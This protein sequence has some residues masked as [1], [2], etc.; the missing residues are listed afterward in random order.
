MG[1]KNGRNHSIL[2]IGTVQSLKNNSIYT[3]KNL[4]N[5]KGILTSQH[6][7]QPTTFIGNK[8][9]HSNNI[10]SKQQINL[11]QN[12]SHQADQEPSAKDSKKKPPTFEEILKKKKEQDQVFHEIKRYTY[13]TTKSDSKSLMDDGI[14]FSG[15][16]SQAEGDEEGFKKFKK[17]IFNDIRS[18]TNAIL[19]IAQQ[20][21]QK[22]YK[23]PQN[24]FYEHTYGIPIPL[25]QN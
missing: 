22:S 23:V 9:F 13:K 5:G 7:T 8:T 11:S 3:K 24:L 19:D 6:S 18:E 4:L 12:S 1:E 21:K 10:S 14:K 2:G 15:R 17:E 20:L 16:N 25:K